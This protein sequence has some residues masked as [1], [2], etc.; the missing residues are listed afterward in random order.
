V[1]CNYPL[2]FLEHKK[3]NLFEKNI[4]TEQVNIPYH[5]IK[6]MYGGYTFQVSYE[7]LAIQAIFK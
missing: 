7:F 2:S 6:E 3:D 5:G 1:L 4:S